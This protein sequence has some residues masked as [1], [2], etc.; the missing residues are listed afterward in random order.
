MHYGIARS[1]FFIV[2]ADV[3]MVCNIRWYLGCFLCFDQL[4]FIVHLHGTLCCVSF[5]DHGV[6]SGHV[7]EFAVFCC[8]VSSVFIRA[9]VIVFVSV[10][11]PEPVRM[12]LR[13]TVH[14]LL[15][16]ENFIFCFSLAFWFTG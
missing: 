14:I 2:F 16:C 12:V 8:F 13:V 1:C 6:I 10:A 9:I 15:I 4:C 3:L 11:K 5:Q 7:V